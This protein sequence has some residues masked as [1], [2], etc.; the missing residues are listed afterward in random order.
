M[1]PGTA[2]RRSP[3]V[4]S[5]S[6]FSQRFSCFSHSTPTSCASAPQSSQVA[7]WMLPGPPFESYCSRWSVWL[8]SAAGGLGEGGWSQSKRQAAGFELCVAL[9]IRWKQCRHLRT[10]PMRFRYVSRCSAAAGAR[11][12]VSR[13]GCDPKATEFLL[14]P[15]S[16]VGHGTGQAACWWLSLLP[17]S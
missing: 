12:E 8:G 4:H 5:P 10:F 9:Q 2:R 1:D 17:L 11:R 15:T 3:K 7:T 14:R 6:A 13:Q 16:A